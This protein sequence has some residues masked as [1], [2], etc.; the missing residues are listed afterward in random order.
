MKASD[1]EK[2]AEPF[3]KEDIHWRAQTVTKD[4]SKAL[5][6]A[7]LDARDVM[8]RLDEVCGIHGWQSEHY[9]CGNGRMGCKIGVYIDSPIEGEYGRW[10]WKSDGA[11]GTD[12]EADKGAFS[13]ALKRAAVSWGIGRYLYGLDSV[14]AP[15]ESYEANGKMRFKKFKGDPWNFVHNTAK[16]TWTGPLAKME[17]KGEMKALSD[18]MQSPSTN[19]RGDLAELAEEYS[20]VIAQA[21]R[22]LPDWYRGYQKAQR[23]IAEKVLDTPERSPADPDSPESYSQ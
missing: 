4:G 7:Y 3:P 11:G 6:L 20:T 12:V 22:D 16:D 1:L 23:Q 2:L 10:I 13:D 18:R 17:L 15:C 9:D 21:Q 14:W 19:T 8:D 5:A